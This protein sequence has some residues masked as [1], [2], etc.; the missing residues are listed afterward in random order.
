MSSYN[1]RRKKNFSV[2]LKFVGVPTF[3]KNCC[4]E[5]NFAPRY[6]TEVRKEKIFIFY[7]PE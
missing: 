2:R 6:F 7:K 5:R 1:F 3:K 4:F